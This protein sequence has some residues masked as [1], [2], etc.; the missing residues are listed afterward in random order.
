[1]RKSACCVKQR[2]CY[3]GPFQSLERDIW[4]WMANLRRITAAARDSWLVLGTAVVSAL[5]G[6]LAVCHN[7]SA[8]RMPRK[9][10]K[11]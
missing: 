9:V 10:A 6:H 4:A 11:V 3:M 5:P 1:M 8:E 7:K 2:A